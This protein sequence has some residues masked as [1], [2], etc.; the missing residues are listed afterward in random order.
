MT[1][2]VNRK[3]VSR[4]RFQKEAEKNKRLMR[5]IYILCSEEY[6]LT[7]EI[8][9]LRGEWRKKFNEERVLNDLI[10]EILTPIKP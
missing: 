8:I 7:P 5:D 4:S 2:P 1:K 9:K 6:S 3:Y 10:K